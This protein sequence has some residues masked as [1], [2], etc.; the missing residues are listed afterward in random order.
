MKGG[1]QDDMTN[2]LNVRIKNKIDSTSGWAAN[3]I[4]LMQGEMGIERT[5]SEG[6]KIKIGDGVTAFSQLPYFGGS[7]DLSSFVT[8]D[9]PS[10]AIE[11]TIPETFDGHTVDEFLLKTDVVNNLTSEATNVPLSAAQ[12]K[13]LNDTI[14]GMQTSVGQISGISESVTTLESEVSVLDSEKLDVSGGTLTGAL[15][16]QSNTNYSVRQVRNIIISTSEPTSSDGQDGDI[17]FVYEA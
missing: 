10:S 6:D 13:I 3:D 5:E 11:G 16:A 7:A 2:E 14:S 8:A 9:D 12:G 15:V 4:V 17:W 1:K